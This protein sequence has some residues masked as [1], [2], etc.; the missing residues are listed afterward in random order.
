MPPSTS[1]RWKDGLKVLLALVLIGVV[2]SRTSLGQ[3][4]G[5][6]RGMSWSWLVISFLLF[7]LTTA[8][9]GVQYW[10]LLGYKT[11]YSQII[12]IVVFQNALSNLVA[13][14]AGVASYFTMF[15][16]DQNV[17]LKRS[18][19][20]FIITK[21]GD[22]VS[23]TIFLS[24]SSALIWGR[25]EILHQMTLVLLTC[26]IAGWIVLM[27]IIPF[28]MKFVLLGVR[29]FHWLRLDRFKFVESGL[30][31]I[32]MLAEQDWKVY[33]RTFLLAIFL[34]LG[35]MAATAVYFFSR[36]QVFHI[37]I[38]FWASVYI[39]SLFQLVSMI[40]IQ[41]FGGLGV[42]EFANMY[43]YTLLGIV[44]ID[45]PAALIGGR[46]L[47]YLFYLVSLLYVPVDMLIARFGSL[48]DN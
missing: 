14:S 13:N 10:A 15:R 36:T 12:K 24:I 26:M 3:I 43:F 39:V 41:V 5:A 27:A 21:I 17:N 33:A 46:V 37:P 22:L 23:V 25:I 8:F 40:P 29:I 32:Q 1:I 35:Y 34:S 47:S 44:N 45:I 38:D 2:F 20:V 4:M 31:L 19:L 9:K 11:P 42:S 28:R 6:I 7:C 30:G 16:M 48:H 18:G